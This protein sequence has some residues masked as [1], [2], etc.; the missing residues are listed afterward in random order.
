M[1][2]KYLAFG[3]LLFHPDPVTGLGGG[4]NAD[5]SITLTWALPP[6]PDV[7]GVTIE[8]E[9][10]DEYDRDIWEI[11]GLTTSFTD[12]TALGGRSYRYWVHTRDSA[13]TLSSGTWI[14]FIGD[15]DHHRSHFLCFSSASPAGGSWPPALAAAAVALCLFRLR[16]IP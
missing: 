2:M 15:H 13:G 11:V 16:R 1:N 14:E 6:D 9:R 12:T 7:V 4:R 8:R 3:L 5:G 10:L